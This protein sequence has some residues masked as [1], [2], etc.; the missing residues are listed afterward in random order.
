MCAGGVQCCVVLLGASYWPTIHA[1][2][3]Q[4]HAPRRWDHGV[5]IIF[6]KIDSNLK[7]IANKLF[8]GYKLLPSVIVFDLLP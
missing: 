4:S 6:L 7:L 5:G 8:P 2:T 3:G 1:H